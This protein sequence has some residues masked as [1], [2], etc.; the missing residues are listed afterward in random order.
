MNTIFVFPEN[1][2]L[3]KG[4]DPTLILPKEGKKKEQKRNHSDERDKI[5]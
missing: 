2:F 5:L 1:A 3:Y 4:K